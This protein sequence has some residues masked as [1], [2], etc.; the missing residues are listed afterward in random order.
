MKYSE[1]PFYCP[2][3]GHLVRDHSYPEDVD[4]YQKLILLDQPVITCPGG[5][6]SIGVNSLC[7]C[8]EDL[9]DTIVRRR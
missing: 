6:E 5:Y 1:A 7:D 9:R 4:G 2:W 3:C 8:T